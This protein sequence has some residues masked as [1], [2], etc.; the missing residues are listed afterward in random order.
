MAQ[1][2]AAIPPHLQALWDDLAQHH[3]LDPPN[4]ATSLFQSYNTRQ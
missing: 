3:Q 4:L 2:N 1:D